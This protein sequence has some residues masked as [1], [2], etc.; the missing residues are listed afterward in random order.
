MNCLHCVI[1]IVLPLTTRFHLS[2]LLASSYSVE[3]LVSPLL[4]FVQGPKESKA[5]LLMAVK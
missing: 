3:Q 5:S 2:L 4:N 1:Y